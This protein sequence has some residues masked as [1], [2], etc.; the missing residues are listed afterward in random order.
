MANIKYKENGEYK[1]IVVKVG[2]TQPIGTIVDYDGA[3]VPNGWEEVTDSF[4]GTLF[5][6]VSKTFSLKPYTNYILVATTYGQGSVSIN[7][8]TNVF[9]VSTGQNASKTSQAI[10]VGGSNSELL[11]ISFT[12]GLTM[13]VTSKSGIWNIVSLTRL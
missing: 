1:D 11:T 10:K 7:T 6:N 9:I 12:D 13:V 2:D 4:S 5:E 8:K 3:E